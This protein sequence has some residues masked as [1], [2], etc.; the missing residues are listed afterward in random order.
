MTCRI[1]RAQLNDLSLEK[2]GNERQRVKKGGNK[3]PFCTH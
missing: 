2:S 1:R 3:L